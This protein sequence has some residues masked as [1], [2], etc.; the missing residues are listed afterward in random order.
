MQNNI[1]EYGD[2]YFLQLLGTAMGTSAACMWAT[3]YFSVHENNTLLPRYSNNLLLYC[4]FIDDIFGIW[5]GNKNG[6]AWAQFRDDCNNFGQ[7]KWVFSEPSKTVDFL[8]LTLYV[9]DGYV[10]TKTFQ[11]TMNLYHYICPSSNHPP[12]MIKGIIYSLLRTYKLQNTKEEDYLEV[13]CLL[14]KR[15]AAR[16]WGRQH[17]KRLILD[18]DFKLRQQPPPLPPAITPAPPDPLL[19]Q[20]Q[21]ADRVFMHIEYGRNDLPRKVVRA[22]FDLTCKKMCEKIG[23]RYFT[24]AYSRSKNIKDL[25]SKSKLHMA[26]GKE[27]SK[28]YS[29]ELSAKRER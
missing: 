29:G 22:I 5:V 7:L 11:K 8:D 21:S 15:H 17:L 23:I 16:G 19:L 9:E 25:V 2:L 27:A 26:P 14:Y 18:A 1:F 28:Y 10:L 12:E 3:I 24:I 13:A 6:L 4:R 20:N